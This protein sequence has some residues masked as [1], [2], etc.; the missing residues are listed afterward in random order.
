MMVVV[1]VIVK[2][3]LYETA[4][5]NQADLVRIFGDFLFPPPPPPRRWSE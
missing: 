5:A 4:L 2:I 3:W 1:V